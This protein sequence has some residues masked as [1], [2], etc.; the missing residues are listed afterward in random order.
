MGIKAKPP[1]RSDARL[2]LAVLYVRLMSG[3]SGDPDEVVAAAGYIGPKAP[4]DRERRAGL[5]RLAAAGL[6]TEVR[7]DVY[8]PAESVLAAWPFEWGADDHGPE[9]IRA[10][11]TW[12]EQLL[13]F[14]P[15]AIEPN[16]L[17]HRTVAQSG[18]RG[19]LRRSAPARP[20]RRRGCRT[21]KG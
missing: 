7:A 3:N 11:L 15:A 9:Q 18:R 16:Q 21:E 14:G 6:L 5:R 13:G 4:P 12:V 20:P 1:K 17:S 10:E 19:W 2:L 8:D